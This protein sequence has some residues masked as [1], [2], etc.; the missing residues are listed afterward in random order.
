MNPPRHRLMKP[1]YCPEVG[2]MRPHSTQPEVLSQILAFWM[3]SRGP[4]LNQ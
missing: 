4:D 2:F 3:L 1:R